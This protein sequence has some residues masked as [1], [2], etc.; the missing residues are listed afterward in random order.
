MNI[1]ERLALYEKYYFHEVARK[2]LILSR[3]NFS[4][5]LGIAISSLLIY[6]IKE[7]MPFPH[8][9]YTYVF[10]VLSGLATVGVLFFLIFLGMLLLPLNDE[11]MQDADDIEGHFQELCQYYEGYPDIPNQSD[12]NL[13]DGLLKS[14]SKCATIYARN[15]HLRS[16]RF[17]RMNIATAVVIVFTLLAM[18]P[19]QIQ[20]L[21]KEPQLMSNNRPP[22]PSMPPTKSTKSDGSRP[23]PQTTNI[24][25]PSTQK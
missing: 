20:S 5:T 11:T 1:D 14:Y 24:P 15:N 18:I 4:V 19:F 21:T 2:D 8:S 22:P 23:Q 6:L 13:K 3:L 9:L 17:Y 16:E 7:S 25:P 10:W 12:M